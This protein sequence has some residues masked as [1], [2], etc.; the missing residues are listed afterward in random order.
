M[1]ISLLYVDA[2]KGHYVPAKAMGDVLAARGYDAPVED[3]FVALDSTFW[4]WFCKAE[5]RFFL[6]HPILERI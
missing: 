6:K 5:W 1:T 2:G 4:H 3:L